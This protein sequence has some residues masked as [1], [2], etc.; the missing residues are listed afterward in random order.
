MIFQRLHNFLS[1]SGRER[2]TFSLT[3]PN[4]ERRNIEKLNHVQ[5]REKRV[6]T[7]PRF[8]NKFLAKIFPKSVQARVVSFHIQGSSRSKHDA[9]CRLKFLSSS[10]STLYSRCWCVEFHYDSTFK[11]CDLVM[12]LFYYFYCFF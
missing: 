3:S 12:P 10:S 9:L 6:S 4:N 8:K 5:Y 1:C 7:L 11:R 2:S